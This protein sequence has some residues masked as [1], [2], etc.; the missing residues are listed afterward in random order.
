[1]LFRS[2]ALRS[3]EIASEVSGVVLE[4]PHSIEPGVTVKRGELLVRLDAHD[5]QQMAVRARE[6]IAG[7]DA[8]IAGLEVERRSFV[9]RVELA[10]ESVLLAREELR[11][12]Q[13]A[14][15]GSGVGEIE[16]NRQRRALIVLD[17]DAEVQKEFLA[18]I[19]HRRAAIAAQI[20]LERANLRLAERDIERCSITARFAGTLQRIDV[21]EGERV[22][23]G[24][25]IARLV[26]LREIEIPLHAP[27]SASSSIRVGDRVWLKPSGEDSASWE[28]RVARIAPE[29]E[30][31]SRTITVFAVVE[32]G[33]SSNAAPLLLPGRFVIGR[34]EG[35]VTTNAVPVPRS[36]ISEDR[37]MIVDSA[38][39]IRERAIDIQFYVDTKYPEIDRLETQW[40]IVSAGLSQGEHIVVSN[41]DEL[42]EGM[43]VRI[44]DTP[45]SPAPI[46]T[47]T[48]KA[49]NGKAEG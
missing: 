3:A 2:R 11:A 49:P 36:A 1:V 14:T 27:L 35:R 12:A 7:L 10:E 6:A 45:L 28:G 29:A 48:A 16:V 24:A 9:T 5:Y 18:Q 20:E 30:S 25:A 4:R 46:E 22:S 34:I 17:R 31:S 47:K 43:A 37:V 13:T 8:Q 39:T 21:R 42:R 41:L 19:P 26:D 15:A 40:A 38:G 33:I 23:P 44:S 32:Q